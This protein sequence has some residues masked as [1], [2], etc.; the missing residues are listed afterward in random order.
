[1]P[2]NLWV[3]Q[4]LFWGRVQQHRISIVHI[5]MV[6]KKEKFVLIHWPLLTSPL[7]WISKVDSKKNTLKRPN[8]LIGQNVLFFFSR[9]SIIN[10]I[11]SLYKHNGICMHTHCA[12]VLLPLKYLN[13]PTWINSGHGGQRTNCCR[14]HM[15]N[16][17]PRP[18]VFKACGYVLGAMMWIWH[19]SSS[20][21][22]CHFIIIFCCI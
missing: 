2:S 14:A 11:I 16:C 20:V 3:R 7:L 5:F 12:K 4:G 17:P 8:M 15:S 18:N 10:W 13:E 19:L 21:E 9:E 22:I 6:K 1:M